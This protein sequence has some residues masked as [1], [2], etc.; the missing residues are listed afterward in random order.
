MPTKPSLLLVGHS[1]HAQ[2]G[3]SRFMQ[4]LLAE[5]YAVSQLHDDSWRPG[6]APL[7]AAAINAQQ[8]DRVL[9]WQQLPARRELRRVR[10]RNLSWAPMHDGIDYGSREWVRLVGSGLKVVN[11]SA[12]G[13]RYFSQLGYDCLPLRY[14]P[15][16]GNLPAADFSQGLELFFWA[17]R[18]A[19]AW[20][21]L[22][23]LLG[24]QRPRRI[25][26]RQAPDPGESPAL[27]SAEEIAEY[28]I[29]LVQGWLEAA[30]YAALL[31][32]C[33]VFVAPRPS[34]GIG[35]AMLEAM[36]RGMAVIAPDAPTM[37]EYLRHGDTG[38]LY[39][40][41]EPPLVDLADAATVGRRA[42]A[43]VLAGH[44]DWQRQVPALLDF[45][46]RPGRHPP[47]WRWIAG[48]WLRR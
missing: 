17:R 33:N 28:R 26:L 43:A 10:C 29:E 14:F 4:E 34:E 2:T 9:F 31:A 36:A 37:N 7:D 39:P 23:R 13:Q 21:L 30:D 20:P 19:I 12:V 16:A 38:Y 25:V 1:Y 42:R 3:S 27:P 40:L 11:F 47:S 6:A 35:M 32:G 24:D 8:P 45:I 46:D 18:E 41:G 44:A 15:Q 22:K 48:S 5:R